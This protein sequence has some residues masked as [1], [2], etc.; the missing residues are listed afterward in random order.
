KLDD[1][2]MLGEPYAYTITAENN[3]DSFDASVPP[4]S[5]LSIQGATISGVPSEFGQ[6]DVEISAT[7]S[8]GTDVES[9]R[10]N[11]D[12]PSHRVVREKELLIIHPAVVQSAP[13][14]QAGG[15]WHIRSVMQR[16]AGE[17]ADVD[18]FAEHWI[19]HWDEDQSINGDLSAKRSRTA[20]VL[21]DA[22]R[23]DRFRLIAIVNRIDLTKHD[24]NDLNA[25]VVKLGEGRF[26]YEVLQ[27]NG[28]GVEPI[29]LIFEFGL[30]VIDDTSLE[31]SLEWWAM[32]WHALGRVQL[33]NASTFPSAYLDELEGLTDRF[34]MHGQL[35]QL[36]TNEFKQSP[37]QL[38]EFAVLDGQLMQKVVV[39]TPSDP[40]NNSP[41]F[42][43]YV[44]DNIDDIIAGRHTVPDAMLGADSDV[45]NMPWR[46]DG[47]NQ[48]ATFI[49]SFNTCNACHQSD[50]GAPFQHIH[51]S[52][53]GRPASLSAFLSREIQLRE[54]LPGQVTKQWDEMAMREGLLA[55]YAKDITNST[56]SSE[57]AQAAVLS[58]G[59]RVH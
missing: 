58:R 14:A 20:Q 57:E 53:P 32:R 23:D 12:P 33:G 40:L 28:A 22:W 13:Q 8:H 6:F 44:R 24:D 54:S 16:L 41:E 7:N 35:N 26:V 31:E 47:E 36:R 4:P 1:T 39:Q 18:A 29:T 17:G 25:K 9:L 2:A 3:P 5:G 15:S 43:Q 48:R 51:N 30:P 50:T 46:A 42:K 11:V 45:K 37:W 34:S 59:P 56:M 27:A 21:R 19:A 38:R 52:G 55:R 49:V 10:L